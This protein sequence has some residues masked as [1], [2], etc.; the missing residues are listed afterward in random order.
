MSV[1]GHLSAAAVRLLAG[2]AGI[3]PIVL[4]GD[5]QPLGVGTEQRF[6]NRYIR[7]AL[8]KRDKGCV[9]CKAPPW[10]CHAHHVIHVRREP[11]VFP[12]GGTRPSRRT[13]PAGRSRGNCDR[14]SPASPHPACPAVGAA[15]PAP[16][17]RSSIAAANTDCSFVQSGC[18][19]VDAADAL[20]VLSFLSITR[21]GSA[22]P[23]RSFR[24]VCQK[25][26]PGFSSDNQSTG[27]H[28]LARKRIIGAVA[29]G[30]LFAIG[31][32]G[33][34]M[35][36]S[37]PGPV[38]VSNAYVKFDGSIGWYPNGVNHGGMRVHGLL[39]DTSCDGNTVYLNGKVS[40]YGYTRLWD[41]R[42]GCGSAPGGTPSN[43]GDKVVFDGAA[44]KVN[45]G[46]IKVCRDDLVD[47][48]KEEYN[49][50]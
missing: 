19:S 38:V 45:Y 20:L 28:M 5:S 40:G 36:R 25:I 27:D 44:T 43:Y 34:A 32:A 13:L 11:R 4:G 8:N 46:W 1:G 29:L 14:R 10:M 18:I 26:S 49:T 50:R 39:Y 2:G 9:V 3:L 17:P 30:G 47:D 42:D 37:G 16:R 22:R 31:I 12:F 15:G 23:D 7:R 33:S 24:E 35:A 6:V 41:K 21:P 48:C